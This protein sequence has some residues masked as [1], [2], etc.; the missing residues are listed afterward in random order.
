[1]KRP[2]V[3]SAF[4]IILMVFRSGFGP[5]SLFPINLGKPYLYGPR[6]VY[7]DIV[8]L[9]HVW[10]LV[11]VKG[12]VNATAYTQHC[13]IEHTRTEQK[14]QRWTDDGQ[15]RKHCISIKSVH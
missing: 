6:F 13:T 9:E 3:H 4:Q 14:S 7:R 15:R 11:P 5:L 10:P 2:G 1:M 12:I 8:L